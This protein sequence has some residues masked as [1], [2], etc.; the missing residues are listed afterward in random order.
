MRSILRFDLKSMSNLAVPQVVIADLGC[1]HMSEPNFRLQK[2]PKSGDCDLRV[3]TVHYRP[4]DVCLGDQRYG[5]ELDM[6]S[7]GCVAAELVSG[8]PLFH[9][10]TQEAPVKEF[11]DAIFKLLGPPEDSTWLESLP[12]FQRWYG[13]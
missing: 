1:C 10:R 2:R 8:L 6:W 7:L 3:C 13:R 9:A 12:Y 11:V 4:P 5:D